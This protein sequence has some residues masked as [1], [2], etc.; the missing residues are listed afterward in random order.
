MPTIIEKNIAVI[1]AGLTGLT[2]AFYLKKN[3]ADFIVIEQNSKVGGVIQTEKHNGYLIETGPN[4]GVVGHPEVAELF[5][6]LDNS[7]EIDLPGK[8]VNKR[9]IL[10]NSKWEPLPSGLLKGITTPLFTFGDKI[11]ILGEPFRKRG[12]NPDETLAQLVLRRMG[13]SFLNYAIDPFIMGVYSGDPARLVTRHALPKLYSLEQTYGSF[14][15]GAIKKGFKKKSPRELK[16]TRKVFSVKGGLSELINALYNKTGKENFFLSAKELSVEYVDGKYFSTFLNSDGTEIIVKSNK[17]ITT[18]GAFALKNILSFIDKEK[19]SPITNLPYANVV[20]VVL[21]FDNYDGF[22]PEGFGGL[23]PF[24]E[25]RDVLGVL[26]MSTL[27]QKRTP[28]NCTLFT[29]FIGGI[30][31]SNLFERTE[32]ELKNIV[33]TEFMQLMKPS[34]FNPN[35]FQLFWHKNAIPQYGIESEERFKTIEMLKKEYSGLIIG[36]NL[37]DGIGMADRIKQGKNLA[38]KAIN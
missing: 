33:E 8:E 4:T 28:D 19:L 18:T 5:E 16:A 37:K 15:G 38:I 32:A 20:E 17:L 31:K 21:G 26:F 36:G 27:F 13:K 1:G 11:R 24:V 22:K 35:L 3:K 23:I 7:C 25:N 2:T 10:K 29:M 12:T 6:D 34:V 14:I 9:F 30:R